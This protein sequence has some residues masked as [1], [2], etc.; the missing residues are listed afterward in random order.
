MTLC[1][2]TGWGA[3]ARGERSPDVDAGATP[4]LAADSGESVADQLVSSLAAEGIVTYFGVPGG[5]IEP[6]F[7]ALARQQRAGRVTLVPM[8]S[9]A[10]AAFA[11]DGYHRAT[12]GIAA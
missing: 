6:L 8:R 5:A 11:A 2:L 7:D 12:G 9:E 1:T 10:G 3:S 4:I